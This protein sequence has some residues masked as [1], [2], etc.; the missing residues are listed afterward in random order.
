[1]QCLTD[2]LVGNARTIEVAGVDVIDAARH[3]CAQHR[4][5]A[6]VVLRRPEY[7]GPASCIAPYPIRFTM[8]SPSANVP[9]L[10]MSVISCRLWIGDMDG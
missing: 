4:D 2:Q 7:A 1:M 3:R 5:C 8:R 9:A 6:L 10:P